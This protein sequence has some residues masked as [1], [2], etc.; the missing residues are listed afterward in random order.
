MDAGIFKTRNKRVFIS[1]PERPVQRVN[2]TDGVLELHVMSSTSRLQICIPLDDDAPCTYATSDSPGEVITID[3]E[4]TDSLGDPFPRPR[5]ASTRAVPERISY[6]LPERP[7]V[8]HHITL[9][10]DSPLPL[11]RL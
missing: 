8:V 10:D 4:L 5:L 3:P 2:R 9:Y 6:S 1:C 11:K 7:D